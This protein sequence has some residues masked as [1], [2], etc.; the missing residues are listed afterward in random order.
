MAD[1]ASREGTS[2]ATPAI[3]DYT[4]R[5]H[6]DHDA[7]LAWAFAAPASTGLPAIQVG[8]SEGKLLYT[9]ARLAS[10]SR[11]VEVGTLA[12]YS[13]LWLARALPSDGRLHTI[14]HDEN[15]VAVARETFTRGGVIDRVTLVHADGVAGLESI[16]S[17]GP[18]DLVFLD[19]DKGRY[20]QYGAWAAKNLRR[21]GLI[22]ADNTFFFGRLLEPT[23][24]AASAVRRFHEAVARDFDSVSIP[25]PDGM[26]VGI[27]R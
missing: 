9:L 3:L 8:P 24:V 11:I 15:A 27:R 18:F 19:A 13:G 25:T 2:Y 12:G 5:I 20:D 22:V 14:D 16:T 7:A 4:A 17:S 6:A 23:D 21:G 10:A 1:I 26:V